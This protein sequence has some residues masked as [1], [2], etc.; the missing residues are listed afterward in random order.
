M[1]AKTRLLLRF[2]RRVGQVAP[3]LKIEVSAVRV[4]LSPS[5]EREPAGSLAHGKYRGDDAKPIRY[6]LARAGRSG[7]A[8]VLP[9]TLDFVQSERERCSS[10][11]ACS[12]KNSSGITDDTPERG[13]FVEAA[14]RPGAEQSPWPPERALA[15][16]AA[17]AT[18]GRRCRCTLRFSRFSCSPLGGN[19]AWRPRSRIPSREE[20]QSE[21]RSTT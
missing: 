11:D 7:G 8:Y 17:G 19:S 4:R 21:R 20:R 9:F 2:A 18:L 5:P 10:S 13:R 1:P 15:G 3:P 6:T 14:T 12:P 16:A